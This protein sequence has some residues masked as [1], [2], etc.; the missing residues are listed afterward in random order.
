MTA[1]E[2][3]AH[4][5]SAAAGRRRRRR[6]FLVGSLLLGTTFALLLL[7]VAFRLFW[8]LPPWFAEF[9]QAGMYAA[10][11]DGTPALQPGYVGSLSLDDASP[12]VRVRINS[13]GM[14]GDEPAAAV[15]A[16]V[17][18]VGDSMVFGYGVEQDDCLARQ[19]AAAAAERGRALVVGNGGVPGY[20]SR[21][22]EEHLRRLAPEF[23][24][25]AFVVCGCLGNDPV[26]DTAPLRTVEAGLMLQGV[27]A[28]LARD[29][30]RMRIALRSRAALWFENWLFAN[31]PEYALSA[32]AVVDVD[33]LQRAAGL[34][35]PPQ[36]WGCLFL[37]VRDP[38]HVWQP[39]RDAGPVVPRL[40]AM[41]RDS[42][43]AMQ[44]VAGDRPIVYVALP[45]SWQL[46]P[47][48]FAVE[49]RQ[50]GFDE[51]LYAF[52]LLR[53]RVLAAA[54]EAGVAAL[55][56]GEA[57]RDAGSVD[58]LYLSDRAHLS[59]RG[60]RVVGRWL[61]ERLL[62]GDFGR[63]LARGAQPSTK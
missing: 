16:R 13:L 3:A 38:G 36:Q 14:R 47:D 8:Q 35:P 20:G 54:A 5:P 31:H 17:L 61:A 2:A 43:R 58:E 4:D 32:D 57:L 28:Q 22:Y 39:V 24:A 62:D 41:L 44:Q 40:M 63:R 33:A 15:G 12:A 26:D 45:M 9:Q 23:G 37:D 34:P 53:Q 21:H 1:A 6:L 19:F 59:A 60:N 29:S 55:D 46:D 10:V 25:D 42:L 7:E 56:A 30:L 11:D 52:G 18:M 27:W 51:Q 48:V 50:R 49:L